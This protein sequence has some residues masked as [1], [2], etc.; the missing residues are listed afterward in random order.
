[1]VLGGKNLPKPAPTPYMGISQR[2]VHT[3]AI[4]EITGNEWQTEVLEQSK[5]QSVIVAFNASWCASCRKMK[6]LYNKVSLEYEGQP[7]QYVS[8]DT[9]DA[10]KQA[11]EYEVRAIPAYRVFKDGELVPE[12]SFG[13]GKEDS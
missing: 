8:L 11:K 9:D 4:K 5:K 3:N 12:L 10:H 2:K 7:I 6:K 13:G 1:M